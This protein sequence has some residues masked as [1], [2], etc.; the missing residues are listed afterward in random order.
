MLSFKL[1]CYP[2]YSNHFE[3]LT[4]IEYNPKFTV[5][6]KRLISP[7]SAYNSDNWIVNINF[8]MA[9]AYA[10]ETWE[11]VISSLPLLANGKFDLMMSSSPYGKL[12]A[13]EKSK[14]SDHLKSLSELELMVVEVCIKYSKHGQFII[15]PSSCE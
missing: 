14:N 13:S 6:A 1:L 5:I 7:L 12:P 10:K 8:I 4:L 11:N 3:S 15:P 2:Y 9:D